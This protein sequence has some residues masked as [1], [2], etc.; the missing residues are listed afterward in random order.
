M[1]NKSKEQVYVSFPSTFISASVD[2]QGHKMLQYL[3]SEKTILLSEKWLLHVQKEYKRLQQE[4][5]VIN[6]QV[7]LQKAKSDSASS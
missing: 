3:L 1:H 2:I 7:G 6:S 4:D 5:T